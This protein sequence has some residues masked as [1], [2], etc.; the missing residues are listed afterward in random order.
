MQ[1]AGEA[2][3]PS[4]SVIAPSEKHSLETTFKRGQRRRRRDRVWKTVPH[5][6]RLAATA[7]GKGTVADGEQTHRRNN[8]SARRRGW[9]EHI[10]HSLEAALFC[11]YALYSYSLI[12]LCVGITLLFSKLLFQLSDFTCL[13]FSHT[14]EQQ[15]S[16]SER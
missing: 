1:H 10:T 12:F 2:A 6:R 14:N 11:R 15:Y 8:E 5:P 7:D 3:E 9:A 13:V 16:F 4:Y